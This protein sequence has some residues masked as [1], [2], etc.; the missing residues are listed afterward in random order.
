MKMNSKS[1]YKVGFLNF[2]FFFFLKIFF[3]LIDKASQYTTYDQNIN[4]EVLSESDEENDDEDNLDG[5]ILISFPCQFLYLH[6]ICPFPLFF[7]S[8][9][10]S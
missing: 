5:S 6:N 4:E 2:F 8:R 9:I 3:V 7:C 1:F 10:F